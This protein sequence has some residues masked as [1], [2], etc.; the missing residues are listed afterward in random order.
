[1]QKSDRLSWRN[2]I[3]GHRR[4]NVVRRTSLTLTPFLFVHSKRSIQQDKHPCQLAAFRPFLDVSLSLEHFG[5]RVL[6]VRMHGFSSVPDLVKPSS[7]TIFNQCFVLPSWWTN[8]L[9]ESRLEFTVAKVSCQRLYLLHETMIGWIF[10]S[11]SDKYYP[12]S[13]VGDRHR[14][15]IKVVSRLGRSLSM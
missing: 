1:M 6:Q 3:V 4:P 2:A 11:M 9:H 8:L 14:A 15:E 5:H 13:T 12:G 10:M 7:F